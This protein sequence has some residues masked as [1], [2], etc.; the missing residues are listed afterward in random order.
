M[1]VLPYRLRFSLLL[2]LLCSAGCGGSLPDITGPRSGQWR[3]TMTADMTLIAQ[4]VSRYRQA[5][6][7][8]P[9]RLD[10]LIVGPPAWPD[11]WEPLLP[12]SITLDDPWQYAYRLDV[13]DYSR[14]VMT[15]L[16]FQIVSAGADH[17]FG[18]DDD[19]A[20]PRPPELYT[21]GLSPLGPANRPA[22]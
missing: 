9:A 11:L 1:P 5:T 13:F 8:F 20:M 15:G 6:G 14:A 3:D 4:A 21:P 18:T 17:H 22:E 10:F 7:S 19:I 12:R 16:D 2:L